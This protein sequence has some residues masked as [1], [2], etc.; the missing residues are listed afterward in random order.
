M[1][2]QPLTPEQFQKARASGFTAA[3]IVEMEKKRKAATPTEAPA[4]AA[5]PTPQPTTAGSIAQGV[6]NFL[7]GALSGFSAPGRTIQNKVFTPVLDAIFGEGTGQQATQAGFEKATHTDLN[8]LPGKA[9]Q[10]AGEA[11]TYLAGPGGLLK[12]GSMKGLSLLPRVGSRVATNA[13][14]STAQ[15]G[16]LAEGT[17][18]AALAELIG[19]AA[20]P[21]AALGKGIYKSLAIPTS[22]KEA[23]KLQTFKADN[24]LLTRVGGAL[25]GTT[26]APPITAA[27]TA[28]S[29]GLMGTES[30]IGVQAKRAQKRVWSQIVEPALKGNPTKVDLPTFFNEARD[31]IIKSTPELSRQ[32]AL[33]NALEAITKDYKGKG[34]VSMEDFQKLKSGWAE[35]V[36]EKAYK[37]ESIAGSFNE[38]KNI[39]SSAA[40]AKIYA[41]IADP[42]V[43]RAYI[44]YGN[45]EGLKEW[46]QKAMTG[47]K[48][49]GGTG[50]FLSAAKDAVLT[51]IAT[52]GGLMT[53]KTANG[54]TFV[55]APG[56]RYLSDII[57][58]DFLSEQSPE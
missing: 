38:V 1:A 36:P 35:F 39:V 46:G 49:K 42:A 5:A 53:Y 13:A 17:S 30:M 34:P 3:Q 50:G 26:K 24:P 21:V 22:A 57:T 45:L 47:G 19:G 9:G 58:G 31:N 2:Y 10:I 52:I 16:D 32:K 6:G 51:P 23:A 55:A 7:G 27:E 12:A 20:K 37:G 8:S 15:S 4:P 14:I 11:A 56:A 43:K 54:V 40:R 33:L 44:D 29:N 48:F 18:S 25:T 41:T 28:F